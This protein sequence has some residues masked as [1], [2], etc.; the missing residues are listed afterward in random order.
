MGAADNIMSVLT[1]IAIF[2]DS[3]GRGSGDS[4]SSPTGRGDYISGISPTA[5]YYNF[6]NK[7]WPERSIKGLY[8]YMNF[9]VPGKTAAACTTALMPKQLLLLDMAPPT[10]AIIELGVNDLM[11]GASASSCELRLEAI[12]TMLSSRYPGIICYV[13]TITPVTNSSDNWATLG[14]QFLSGTLP[15]GTT[16]QWALFTDNTQT[17]GR[18]LLNSRIKGGFIAGAAG[19]ID[20][21]GQAQ[22]GTD[23]RYWNTASIPGAATSDGIHP[24]QAMHTLIAASYNPVTFFG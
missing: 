15:N 9:S 10:H 22:D 12:I 5:P 11:T 19:Y 14:N 6:G 23:E 2:G 20:A 8:P 4:R 18:S 3:I 21:A 7:G 16:P 13:S 17:S 1:N 24:V